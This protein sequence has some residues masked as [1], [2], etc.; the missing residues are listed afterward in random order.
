MI[1]IDYSVRKGQSLTGQ[2]RTCRPLD[3]CSRKG[4]SLVGH[5]RNGRSLVG[6]PRNDCSLVGYSRKG[7]SLVG[8]SKSELSFGWLLKEYE[9]W[10]I[11]WLPYM[12]GGS[13]V[14]CPI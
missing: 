2:S 1:F 9:W 7:C 8:Y 6:C 14:G 10:F 4:N 11:G 5:S 3:G 13:L 12:N